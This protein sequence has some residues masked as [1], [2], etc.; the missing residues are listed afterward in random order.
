MWSCSFLPGMQY[1]IYPSG[2]KTDLEAVCC[3]CNETLV[4]GNGK[5]KGAVLKDHVIQ[6]NFRN[7]NQ[8]LYFSGQRFRQHLQDSHKTN[9]DATL[10][11][12]WTL[13]LKS[14]KKVRPSVFE[15]LEAIAV[16]RAYTDPSSGGVGQSSKKTEKDKKGLEPPMP[17]MNFMDLSAETPQKTPKRKIRRKAS[18]QTMPEQQNDIEVRSSSHFFT[19][20]ATIDLAYGTSASPSPRNRSSPPR[21]L[22]PQHKPGYPVSSHPVDAASSCPRFYRRRLD[23]STRNRLYVRDEEETGPLSKNSQRLFRGVDGSVFG[24]LVLHSSLVAGV[25]AR[26]TNGVDVYCLH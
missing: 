10:F 21:Y 9:H 12:G 4:R 8:R 3:Y 20:A 7:C 1:T 24:G 16:R 18:T 13:L 11:A 6:H 17:K 26:M 23:A 19:R 5:V 14:C 22:P 15:T 2:P 25:G